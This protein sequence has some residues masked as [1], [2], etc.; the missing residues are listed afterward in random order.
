MRVL[1]AAADRK[2]KSVGCWL[3]GVEPQLP[4]G[5]LIEVA[6]EAKELLKAFLPSTKASDLVE[7]IFDE[8]VAS[9]GERPTAGEL[10]RMG[11]DIN[12]LLGKDL[13]WFAF[14]TR[15]GW[16]PPGEQGVARQ[17]QAWFAE[18]Q[19]TRMDKSYKMVTLEVLLEA[20][21]LNTGMA[22]DELSE[23]ARQV[24]L[25]STELRK[26]LQ[27][28][29]DIPDLASIAKEQWLAY[30]KRN[31][32][33][34]WTNKGELSWFRTD[35]ARLIPKLPEVPG[36]ETLLATMTRELVDY[37]LAKYRNRSHEPL[38]GD[39]AFE[40]KVTWNQRNPILK[41]PS[42]DLRPR[43]TVQVRL[44]NDEVWAFR[45]MAQF[46]NVAHPVGETGNRLPELLREWFGP[47]AGKPGTQYRVH[48]VREQDGWAVKPMGGVILPSVNAGSMAPA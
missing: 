10:Y 41:I 30:W 7:Q 4:P 34:A 23:R 24:L 32:V 44:L 13:T 14:L 5:C 3:E 35:G 27:G 37:R 45:L 17:A 25:R 29:K 48:F 46:C 20:E 19:T 8:Q 39:M 6:W 18:L 9:R 16:L 43:G 33:D 38:N 42:A 15:K 36:Q 22:L 31:P 26:D 1:L 47:D 21:A 11:Y 2:F 28:V 12:A 40:A